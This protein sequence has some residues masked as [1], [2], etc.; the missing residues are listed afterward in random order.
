MS[1]LDPLAPFAGLIEAVAQ[2]VAARVLG[3]LDSGM[4]DQASSPLGSRRHRAAVDRRVANGEGGAFKR[5][6][7]CL[8][9]REALTEELRDATPLPAKVAKAE[10]PAR[11]D[12]DAYKATLLAG[13]PRYR[14]VR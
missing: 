4:I 12:L 14:G 9:T 13:A 7:K 1:T 3:A 2:R 10:P 5:G 6:R 8:L 11:A